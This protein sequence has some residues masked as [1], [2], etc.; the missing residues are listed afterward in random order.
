MIRIMGGK[1]TYGGETCTGLRN[2]VIGGGYMKQGE[3]SIREVKIGALTIEHRK[4][5]AERDVI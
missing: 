2:R 5:D 3:V 1:G 4:D